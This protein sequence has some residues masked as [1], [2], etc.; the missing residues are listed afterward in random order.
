MGLRQ[1][2][3]RHTTVRVGC[4]QTVVVRE[5]WLGVLVEGLDRENCYSAMPGAVTYT[6]RKTL[7]IW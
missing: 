5:S 3:P 1:L 2:K 6:F 7:S 4:D